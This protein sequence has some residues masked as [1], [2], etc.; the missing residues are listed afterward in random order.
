MKKN[1]II[2]GVLSAVIVTGTVVGVMLAKPNESVEIEPTPSATIEPTVEPECSDDEDCDDDCCTD[3]EDEVVEPT[4][5]P[6]TSPTTTPQPSD[7][8]VENESTTS[9]TI[10]PSPT[11]K[12]EVTTTPELPEPTETAKPVE[13]STTPTVTPEPEI[14]TT[15]DPSP[16]TEPTPT[17]EDGDTLYPGMIAN[18]VTT[19]DF[20]WNR[21][22]EKGC[23]VCG[24][25]TCPAYDYA[26]HIFTSI[27]CD[28]Y[29]EYESTHCEICG[30]E[31]GNGT[32]G[33]CLKPM[34]DSICY[35]CG[36]EIYAG[37]C[38]TCK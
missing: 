30:K 6:T 2:A 12:P 5:S 35:Y 33:T 31:E 24:S 36:E 8:P 23:T 4:I 19:S 20:A 10:T 26:N 11:T 15:P 38:H 9:P 16:S 32:N 17:P 1:R 25:R 29:N 27:N 34:G 3:E 18:P 14:E 21:Y 13:P 37:E 22:V 7:E 28:S